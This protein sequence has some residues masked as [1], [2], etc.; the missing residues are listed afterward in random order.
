MLKTNWGNSWGINGHF[1][2]AIGNLNDDNYGKCFLANT[3]YNV[4]PV[5]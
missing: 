5:V 1:K 2:M 3:P 4:M